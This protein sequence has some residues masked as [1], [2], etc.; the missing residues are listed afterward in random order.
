M[1]KDLFLIFMGCFIVDLWSFRND[2]LFRGRNHLLNAVKH[3]NLQIEEFLHVCEGN[4]G[5]A[6]K[7]FTRWIKINMDASVSVAAVAFV[8]REHTRKILYICLPLA[9][10]V[11]LFSRLRLKHWS[12][13]HSLGN[14]VR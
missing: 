14:T 6:K 5:T 3:F 4:E 1:G 10:L 2:H 7:F 8:V 13:K 12:G 11:V 9:L